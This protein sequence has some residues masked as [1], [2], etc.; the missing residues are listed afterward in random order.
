[1]KPIFTRSTKTHGVRAFGCCLWLLLGLELI[2]NSTTAQ[3]SVTDSP[4]RWLSLVEVK[5]KWG[6]VPLEAVQRAAEGGDLTAQHY[7]GYCYAEGFRFLQNS[8]LGVRYYERAGNAGYLPSLNNLGLLYQ[9]GKGVKPDIAKAIYYYRLAANSG[10]A[11]AQANMGI[12]YRD[13]TGIPQDPR[14]AMNW[15]KLAAGQGH[16]VAMVEIGRL[17]RFGNGVPKDL[18]A[19]EEWFQKAVNK[20][21]ALGKLN[22]GLLYGEDENMPEKAFHLLQQ[23]AETGQAEAMTSLYLAY[24][25]GKGVTSD[26][27]EALKWLTKAAEANDAYAQCM[28][29]DSYENL[30]W[31]YVGGRRPPSNMPEAIRWYRRSAEQDW[32]GG[33]LHLGLCYIAGNGVEQ[34][35]AR[36]LELIRQAADQNHPSS[37]VELAKLYGRGIGE[38]RNDSDRAVALL[39][40]VANGNGDLREDYYLIKNAYETLVFRYEYGVGTERDIIAAVQWYCRG[41]IAG[42]EGFPIE[43]E[44]EIGPARQPYLASYGSDPERSMIVVCAPDAGGNSDRFFSVLSE[45]LQAASSKNH[46]GLLQIGDLYVNGQDTPKN[47]IKAWLWFALA[48]TNE[49]PGANVR[50]SNIESHM[51]E[52]ELGEAKEFL[53]RF[54]QELKAIADALRR[55]PR[56]QNQ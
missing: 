10:L 47:A 16:T 54:A 19:A 52:K 41:A 33:L 20:G 5:Q 39:E 37:M 28:L 3:L 43:Q 24:W 40:R 2:G 9:K 46:V 7:L 53:P 22:L 13:G 4:S 51:T 12:L 42:I 14:E 30:R 11:Q 32:A 27:A 56:F 23:A 1:M 8:P 48:S 36:G 35:E 26:R 21:D 17:Y 50:L 29:G 6:D 49:V 44:V 55:A 45:Y 25:N 34:D 18:T 15:F 38:P 31:D